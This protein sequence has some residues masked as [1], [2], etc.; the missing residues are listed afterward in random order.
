MIGVILVGHGHFASGLAAAV[1]MIA[2]DVEEFTPID[3]EVSDSTEDLTKKID[4][5]LGKYDE[6]TLILADMAGG[7]PFT[8]AAL[9]GIPKKA[10]IVAGTN[11]SMLLEVLSARSYIKDIKEL[12][13]LAEKTGTESV[14]RFKQKYFK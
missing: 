7:S 3:F 14:I 11:L 6:P 4:A 10:E 2:G 12:A 5:V 13:E 8:T 9:C 1:E